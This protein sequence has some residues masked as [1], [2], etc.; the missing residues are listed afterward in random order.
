MLRSRPTPVYDLARQHQCDLMAE[1]ER[2]RLAQMARLVRRA[3]ADPE[4]TSARHRLAA[5]AAEVR[6]RLDRSRVQHGIEQVK[7]PIPPLVGDVGDR[8]AES[9]ERGRR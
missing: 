3:S 5:A 9:G 7:A 2:E 1:A 8:L 6:Q 4:R